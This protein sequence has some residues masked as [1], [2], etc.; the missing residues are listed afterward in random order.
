MKSS[1]SPE[2]KGDSASVQTSRIVPYQIHGSTA[3]AVNTYQTSYMQQGVY[4]GMPYYAN[5][6]EAFANPYYAPNPGFFPIPCLPHSDIP[7]SSNV[8]SFSPHLCQGIDYTQA[9]SGIC[10]PYICPQPAPYSIPPQN[11]QEHWYAV[12]GQPHYMQYAPVLPVSADAGC[13]G[14]T[15]NINQNNQTPECMTMQVCSNL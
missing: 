13:N 10:P 6:A 14:L 4:S 3:T 15:Q 1:K 2:A 7:D 9:Y 11:M 5:E 12:A 8:Q